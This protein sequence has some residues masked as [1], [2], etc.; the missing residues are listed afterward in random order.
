MQIVGLF[1]FKL[2]ILILK[3]ELQCCSKIL[4]HLFTKIIMQIWNIIHEGEE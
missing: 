1:S 2:G 3:S 4:Y